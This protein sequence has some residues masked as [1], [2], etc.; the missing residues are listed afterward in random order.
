MPSPSTASEPMI[1]PSGTASSRLL[2]ISTWFTDSFPAR[3]KAGHCNRQAWAKK[4]EAFHSVRAGDDS[5]SIV[6]EACQ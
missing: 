6:V 4:K 3:A 2:S 5:D 1:C